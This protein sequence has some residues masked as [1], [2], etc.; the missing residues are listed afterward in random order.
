ML[1]G[2]AVVAALT[3]G[4][5]DDNSSLAADA[6]AEPVIESEPSST[7]TTTTETA[8]EPETSSTTTT[9]TEVPGLSLISGEFADQR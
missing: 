9:T 3:L 4:G 5:N 7:T 8:P 2:V 1:V 6:N